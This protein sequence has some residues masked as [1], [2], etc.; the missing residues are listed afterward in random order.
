MNRCAASCLIRNLTSHLLYQ[1]MYDACCRNYTAFLHFGCLIV[2]FLEMQVSA[3][4]CCLPGCHAMLSGRLIDVL[5]ESS[6]TLFRIEEGF[7]KTSVSTRLYGG[8]Y[9]TTVIFIG[10]RN[11]KSADVSTWTA[12]ATSA[13][14]TPIKMNICRSVYVYSGR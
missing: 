6:A 12:A 13:T 8:Q 4:Y 7:P 3:E 2:D 1:A 11:Y 10:L 5:E 14:E 9:R